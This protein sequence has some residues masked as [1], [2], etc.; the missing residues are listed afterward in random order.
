MKRNC[1]TPLWA[2]SA[3]SGLWP[4]SVCQHDDF[5]SLHS[6]PRNIPRMSFSASMAQAM[7]LGREGGKPSSGFLTPYLEG[8]INR[9]KPPIS[10]HLYKRSECQILCFKSCPD[11]SGDDLAVQLSFLSSASAI[12]TL[13]LPRLT[14]AFFPRRSCRNEVRRLSLHSMLQSFYLFHLVC[15]KEVCLEP[16]KGASFTVRIEEGIPFLIYLSLLPLIGCL[17]PAKPWAVC[18]SGS[19]TLKAK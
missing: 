7:S 16:E 10:I 4:R 5:V 19:V 2:L 15:L 1:H 11:T 14:P 13:L 8:L 9:G 12:S 6:R 17:P 3:L 18:L